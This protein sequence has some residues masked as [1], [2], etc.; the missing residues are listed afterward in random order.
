MDRIDIKN[1]Y[2]RTYRSSIPGAGMMDNP[3]YEAFESGVAKT[4]AYYEGIMAQKVKEA[5]EKLIAEI[6]TVYGQTSYED[7]GDIQ[8]RWVPEKNWQQL[9][10]QRGIA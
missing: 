4:A 6:E 2:Y 3:S 5:E 10:K 1:P 8:G 9:K 7:N